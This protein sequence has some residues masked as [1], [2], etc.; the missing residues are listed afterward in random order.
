MPGTVVSFTK[1]ASC[2][3]LVGVLT[4][5][6]VGCGHKTKPAAAQDNGSPAVDD[7]HA[8][9]SDG[10]GTSATTVAGHVP[11]AFCQSFEEATRDDRPKENDELPKRTLAGKSVGVLYE[12]VR[13][14]W[15]N[16]K[17][18]SKA[19]RV[20]V[21]PVTIQTDIGDIDL[22]LHPE[23]APNHVRSFL[24]LVRVG[25]YEGLTFDRRIEQESSNPKIPTLQMI[26]AGCPLG[27]GVEQMGSIGYWLKAE[28]NE[29]VKHEEG[30][31]G[32]W[33]GADSDTAACRFYICLSNAPTMDGRFTAFAKI[34][35]GIGVARS[36]FNRPYRISDDDEY[37]CHRFDAPP[38][39][40]KVIV[41]D[42]VEGVAVE[43]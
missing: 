38:L 20:L 11:A 5:A 1:W 32:A 30:T 35:K 7:E 39:I 13:M 18:V 6:I 3:V 17:L 25:Y 29:D 31:I 4:L 21:Y 34:T 15:D 14:N 8:G 40:Q 19:G 42:P 33:H 36:I 26:E 24:A 23:W 10:S 28:F 2:T 9:K 16:V 27:L 22:E 37:G 43:K 41:H 12:D